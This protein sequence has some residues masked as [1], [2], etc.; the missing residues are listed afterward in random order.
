MRTLLILLLCL[1][2]WAQ[3]EKRSDGLYAP[4]AFRQA[5]PAVGSALPDALLPE[6]DGPLRALSDELGRCLVLVNGSYT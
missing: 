5:A 4:D 1:P 3:M 2:A 6:L